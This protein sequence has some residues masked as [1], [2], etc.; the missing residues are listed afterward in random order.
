MKPI[1]R[2][3]L[4]ALI[5]LAVATNRRFSIQSLNRPVDG[6]REPTER[7]P[8]DRARRIRLAGDKRARKNALRRDRLQTVADYR[9]AI[10]AKATA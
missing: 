6:I 8:A 5:G 4:A 10:H 7:T 3:D 9:R 1:T 2:L